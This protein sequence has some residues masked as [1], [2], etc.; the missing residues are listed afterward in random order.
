MK[1]CY[2]HQSTQKKFRMKKGRR[3]KICTS[4]WESQ[5]SFKRKFRNFPNSWKCVKNFIRKVIKSKSC[6]IFGWLE[7]KYKTR[8]HRN[9]SKIHLITWTMAKD[10]KV[11]A[12][13][14]STFNHDSWLSCPHVSPIYFYIATLSNHKSY[15]TAHSANK[16]LIRVSSLTLIQPKVKPLTNERPFAFFS[17]T[18]VEESSLIGEKYE[19]KIVKWCGHCRLN[20]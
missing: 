20:P 12:Q 4:K 8:D 1:S 16:S 14:M 13:L 6:G 17:S 3:W 18:V 9:Q 19:R 2:W 7:E 5:K 11:S 15:M 10:I